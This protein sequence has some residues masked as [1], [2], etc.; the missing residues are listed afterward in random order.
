MSKYPFGLVL[1]FGALSLIMFY[2]LGAVSIM[3]ENINETNLSAPL[4]GA[5]NVTTSGVQIGLSLGSYLPIIVA[6]IFL[7]AI[8]LFLLK[9]I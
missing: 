4:Y 2:G 7:I 9:K 6:V 1:V 5:Y 3:D 8:C